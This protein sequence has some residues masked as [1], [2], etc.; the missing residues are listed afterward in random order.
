MT[1]LAPAPT[2]PTSS[3]LA[4]RYTRALGMPEVAVRLPA[5]TVMEYGVTRLPTVR[6]STERLFPSEHFFFWMTV[7][8]NMPE[9]T[10]QKALK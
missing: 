4:S 9:Y 2:I 10:F 8:E 3:S 1:A 5:A 7:I 6:V